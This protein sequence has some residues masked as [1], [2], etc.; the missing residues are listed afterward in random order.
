MARGMV[1]KLRLKQAAGRPKT[2]SPEELAT[3]GGF[4]GDSSGTQT[5]KHRTLRKIRKEQGFQY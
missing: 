5:R 3:E 2:P 4:I 1:G